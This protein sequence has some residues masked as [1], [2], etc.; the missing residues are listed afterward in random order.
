MLKQIKTQA[1]GN[2]A[3][4]QALSPARL[5]NY[6]R[7]FGAADDAQALGLYQWNEELSALLFRTISMVEVVLRNRFHTA[8]SLRYGAIGPQG[9][10]D[11]YDF[12]ALDSHSR[13]KITEAQQKKKRG[14]TP[15]PDDV[16]A[17][18]T[19]GFWPSL[20]NLKMDQQNQPVD[21]GPI[22]LDV[23]PGHRDRLS[24]QWAKLKNR[25]ALFAR[26]ELCKDLRN[27]VA[28]H[29]PIWRLGPLMQELRTRKGVV[30][31]VELHA[32]KD[33]AE[34]LAR[35]RLLYGRVT[36]LLGWLSPEMAA[37][38][39]T[40]ELH[41]RCLTLMR[42]EALAAYQHALPPAEIDLANVRNMRDLRKSM[43]YASRRQQPVL[44]KVG[45][46][47]IGHL[48]SLTLQ[49]K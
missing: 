33:P 4:V 9:S 36:E 46:R 11:W 44:L 32:P 8:F 40:S 21:W 48:N 12:V 7:F 13:S 30:P 23:L 28:H 16:I 24:A 34:A 5:R 39:L 20:L 42:L 22:M 2:L 25:D 18:L 43:R 41:F 15:N 17:G 26:L 19:F 38:H 27:R 45:S 1:A 49:P 6:R 47:T 37:Q 3:R 14:R 31:S 29:E 35:L 10:K